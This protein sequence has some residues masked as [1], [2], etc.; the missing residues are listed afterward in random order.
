MVNPKLS[1]IAQA[2]LHQTI[3]SAAPTPTLN[4]PCSTMW[5]AE[6]PTPER[7]MRGCTR[8]ICWTKHCRGTSS[9]RRRGECCRAERSSVHAWC[10]QGRAE[11]RRGVRIR[12]SHVRRPRS[13][14]VCEFPSRTEQRKAPRSGPDFGSPFFGLL[15]FGEAK[16]SESAT[17]P[18][19]GVSHQAGW[20][21][22]TKTQ[23]APD[24]C[25]AH[26]PA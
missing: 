17:G 9:L 16:K 24:C 11:Q 26:I 10:R 7:N 12:N 4:P 1:R 21:T 23:S 18:K 5:S 20:Q 14:Q 2:R 6:K 25:K 3:M 19:P 22:A 13:G 15:F 8:R